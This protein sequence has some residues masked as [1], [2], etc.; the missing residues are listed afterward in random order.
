MGEVRL[1]NMETVCS[2]N[3]TRAWQEKNHSVVVKLVDVG[4]VN[5][6]VGLGRVLD[7]H[8]HHWQ[9]QKTT[10]DGVPQLL[11]RGTRKQHILRH[12]IHQA[13]RMDPRVEHDAQ[14]VRSG[15]T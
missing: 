3:R 13:A 5:K 1:C 8:L 14:V 9:I 12:A 11:Q 10:I 6:S 4:Y 2:G 7:A 15:T